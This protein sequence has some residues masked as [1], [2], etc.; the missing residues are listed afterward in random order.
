MFFVSNYH[1]DQTKFDLYYAYVSFKQKRT[2]LNDKIIPR[3]I[4]EPC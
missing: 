2:T 1:S 4:H 3:E